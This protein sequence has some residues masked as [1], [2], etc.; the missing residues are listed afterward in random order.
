MGKKL[1]VGNLS[2]DV[3]S[4]ALQQLFTTH[5]AVESAEMIIDR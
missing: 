4:S 1:Y 2:Y 5:G 3:D